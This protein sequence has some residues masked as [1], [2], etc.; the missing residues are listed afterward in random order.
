LRSG[1]A[2]TAAAKAED[3]TSIESIIWMDSRCTAFPRVAHIAAAMLLMVLAVVLY[4]RISWRNLHAVTDTAAHLAFARQY[5]ETGK[6]LPPHFLYQILVA[7]LVRARLLPSFEL[8]GIVVLL[9]FYAL[10][11]LMLYGL[12][13]RSF[14]RHPWLGNAPVLFALAAATMLAQPVALYPRYQIGYFWPTHHD[15]PGSVLA[16]PFS[17]V[18]FGCAAWCLSRRKRLDWKLYAGCAVAVIAG[19]LAKPSYLI[20]L[21]PAAA[22]LAAVRLL[23]RKRL[24]VIGLIACLFGPAALVLGWQY[25]LTYS[26]NVGTTLYRDEIIWAPLMVMRHHASY[27]GLKFLLSIL[28][29]LIVTVAHWRRARHDPGLLLAWATFLEGAFYAYTL[30]EKL[31]AF[32]GNFLWSGYAALFILYLA[33]V[34]FWLREMPQAPEDLRRG[35]WPLRA[36]CAFALILHSTS[37]VLVMWYY[38]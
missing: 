21:V 11:A 12:F 10:T 5:V 27:L 1:L 17:I 13:Y 24:S 22:S 31:R 34:I 7:G 8:A 32:A 19:A 23:R 20:C 18:V 28:F 29:P 14:H 6:M 3:K 4:G 25:Y 15:N 30:A 9:L 37:G 26:G 35:N 38:F 2:A 16:K 36:L 33:S